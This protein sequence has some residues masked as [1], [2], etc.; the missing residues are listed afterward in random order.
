MIDMEFLKK[1]KNSLG[2]VLKIAIWLSSVIVGFLTYPNVKLAGTNQKASFIIVVVI[3]LLLV[4][5][6]SYSDK[7]YWKRFYL[8]AIFSILLGGYFYFA[9]DNFMTDKSAEYPKGSGQIVIKGN[10]L[11]DTAI[12]Y[13]KSSPQMS[14]DDLINAAAGN[15]YLVWEPEGIN[16]NLNKVKY[17]FSA[18]I[19][20]ITIFLILVVNAVQLQMKR[21]E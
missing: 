12:S 16:E 8:A 6:I 2:T 7:K 17:L 10:V 14:D 21:K 4:L 3:L 20:F 9:Y 5:I 19:F 1:F 11:T 13:K 18:Y 15:V